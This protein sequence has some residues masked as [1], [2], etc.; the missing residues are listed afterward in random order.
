MTFPQ[1][2]SIFLSLLLHPLI[3]CILRYTNDFLLILGVLQ[4]HLINVV[5]H[6][7][8]IKPMH[9]IINQ[10]IIIQFLVD[11]QVH[12]IISLPISL[13][14]CQL[15]MSKVRRRHGGG[16]HLLRYGRQFTRDTLQRVGTILTRNLR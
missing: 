14:R 8:N 10:I 16:L 15:G 12:H 2:Q 1:S 3:E 11:A 7:I 5:L 6:E 13:K 9:R 4:Q